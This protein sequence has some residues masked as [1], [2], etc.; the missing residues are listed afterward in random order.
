[1]DHQRLREA[2]AELRPE[3]KL[4]AT[5]THW[6]ET[7]AKKGPDTPLAAANYATSI[8]VNGHVMWTM[9]GTG[10][11]TEAIPLLVYGIKSL[12][13]VVPPTRNV[14]VHVLPQLWQYVKYDGIGRRAMARGGLNGQLKPLNC[15]PAIADIVQ[16]F[17]ARRWYPCFQPTLRNAPGYY[18]AVAVTKGKGKTAVLKHKADHAPT[19]ADHPKPIILE[20]FVDVFPE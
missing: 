12:L 2:L 1:M 8:L 15:Y 18:A 4:A 14:E 7:P 6:H 11:G 16:A 3:D 19:T 5:I 17:D 13:N 20:E 9:W 10:Y